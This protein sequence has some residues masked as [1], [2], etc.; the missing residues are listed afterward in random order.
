MQRLILLVG[1]ALVVCGCGLLPPQPPAEAVPVPAVPEPPAQDVP[2]LQQPPP[3]LINGVAGRPVSWC[4]IG[5]CADGFVHSPLVL[6][7]VSPPF[8]VELPEGARIEGVAGVGPAAA[9]GVRV[10]VEHDGT[11]IGEVPDGAVMLNVFVR[12]DLRGDGSYYW[13]LADAGG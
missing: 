8:E 6:P 3:V 5:G 11:E 13:A 2:A 10:E 4:W 9:G 1:L 12:F 7:E